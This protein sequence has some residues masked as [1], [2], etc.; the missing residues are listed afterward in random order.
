VFP[1]ASL[2]M[3]RLRVLSALLVF[4]RFTGNAQP[5]NDGEFYYL[6]DKMETV[7]EQSQA[8]MFLNI[9]KLSDTAWQYDYYNLTGPRIRTETFRDEDGTIPHGLF[10]FY[11]VFG[12][13]DSMGDAINGRREG[14]WCYFM[15]DNSFKMTRIKYYQYGK[16]VSEEDL[17]VEKTETKN[18][19]ENEVEAKFKGS[20]KRFLEDNLKYPDRAL[21]LQYGNI[22]TF[23]FLVSQQGVIMDPIPLRSIEYSL[24]HEAERVINRSSRKWSPGYRN[25]K[26]VT[27]WHQQSI[28]FVLPEPEAKSNN[29]Q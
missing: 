15:G 3:I 29:N 10:A 20:F 5:K 23:F 25:G 4:F 17:T 19:K 11:N 12:Y 6:N 9:R 2:D 28:N 7:K 1:I 18:E 8:T 13:L 16:L 22:V 24:D 27:S 26:P 21:N 14:N